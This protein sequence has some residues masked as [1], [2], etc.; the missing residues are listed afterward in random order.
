MVVANHPHGLLDG[1]V[2]G[3]VLARRRPDF[4]FLLNEA[5]AKLPGIQDFAIPVDVFGGSAQLNAVAALSAMRWLRQGGVLVA[6]PAG[7]VS[8][9]SGV[10][11][12]V[13]DRKWSDGIVRIAA[14]TQA[15]IVRV[16]ISGRNSLPFQLAGL[17]H[18]SMRTVLLGRELLNKKGYR[19]EVGVGNPLAPDVERHDGE[20]LKQRTYLLQKR[21]EAPRKPLF[22][23]RIRDIASPVEP[24]RVSRTVAALPEDRVLA[25]AGDYRVYA[26]GAHELPGVLEEIGRLRELSFRGEGEGTGN[27]LDLD[28]FDQVY[29]HLFVWNAASSEIVGA[30][31]MG[32]AD[33]ILAAQGARGLYTTTLFHFGRPFLNR[34]SPG[35]ELGRSF[36]RPEYQRN[37]QPLYLLW[38]AIG[39]FVARNPHYRYLFGP[40]SISQEYSHTS[41]ELIVGYFDQRP[42]SNTFEVRPRH[43]WPANSFHP[44]PMGPELLSGVD[45]LASVIAELEPDGKKLPVLLRQYLGMGAQV[46]GFNVDRRFSNALDA[47]IIVDLLRCRNTALAKYFGK[48]PLARY[49][50]YHRIESQPVVLKKPA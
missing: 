25:Q 45:E 40:V 30:Y 28:G 24:A 21:V 31:R 5:L 27:S 48:E 16:F 13:T 8:A 29:T 50:A 15:Q 41:R 33:R 44:K 43:P 22:Q 32:L 47:L 14:S 26:A 17:A 10:P 2:L 38:R 6:F 3:S 18:P 4:R 37:P 11:G 1:L 42:G 34:V 12:P 35:I 36:V 19:V 7:E 49:L 23:P 20:Y 39:A 9:I 46:I